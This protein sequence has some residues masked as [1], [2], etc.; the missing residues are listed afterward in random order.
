M[1]SS[2][3][4]WTASLVVFALLLGTLP[5]ATQSA[6]TILLNGKVLTLDDQ[7]SMV[8][9]LAIREGK[10]IA[11]GPSADVARHADASTRVIDLN[12]RTVIPG[13]IDSHIHAIRAGLKFSVEVSWI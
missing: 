4:T 9:A 10:I 5:A 6:D 8:Q 7:S 3:A 1:R 13:L 11:T 2:R 12:G